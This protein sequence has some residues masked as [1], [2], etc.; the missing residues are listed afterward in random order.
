MSEEKSTIENSSM[1]GNENHNENS[2]LEQIAQA[3]L[4]LRLGGYN[5]LEVGA[6]YTNRK[7]ENKKTE[8]NILSVF[9]TNPAEPCNA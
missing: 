2:M 7:N 9:L 1:A 6:K 3:D 5:T 8:R 4:S